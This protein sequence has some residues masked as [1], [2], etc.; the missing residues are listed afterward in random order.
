MEVSAIPRPSASAGYNF[1]RWVGAAVAPVLSGFH[2][3]AVSPRFPFVIAVAMLLV[4]VA[5]LRARQTVILSGLARQA[6]QEPAEPR[7][8]VA[9]GRM[10][11]TPRPSP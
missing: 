3:E 6:D 10:N 7:R 5:I 9:A 11:L 1:L 2:A 8:D 4:S